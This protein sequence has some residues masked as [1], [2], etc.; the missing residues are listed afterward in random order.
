M[1]AETRVVRR[2][3]DICIFAIRG[4]SEV[5]VEKLGIR[6]FVVWKAMGFG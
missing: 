2:S 6:I 3:G 4:L 5:E 1:A